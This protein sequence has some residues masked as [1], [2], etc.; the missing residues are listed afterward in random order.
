VARLRRALL[1][2]FVVWLALR[3]WAALRPTVFPYFARSILDLPRPL[4]TRAGLVGILAPRP[5][6]RILELGPDTGYYTLLVAARIGPEGT[7]EILDVRQGFLDHTIE[8]A[9][10]S[11]HRNVVATCGDARSLPYPDGSFDAA[12][13]VSVLGEIPDPPAALRE[14]R[15]VLKPEGRIVVGEIFIDPDFPRFRW[16]VKQAVAAGLRLGRRT[17]TPLAYFAE[18]K[19]I[20][21]GDFA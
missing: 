13:L 2:G 21:P 4:I 19:A 1:G 17:G 3:A 15:R 8:R 20:R 16:I 11:G 7:L 9:R 6:E 14:L 12:Y 5:G 18:F 10:R